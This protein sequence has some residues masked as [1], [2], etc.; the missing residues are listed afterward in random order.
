MTL[1]SV[2][3][4]LLEKIILCRV[5][6]LLEQ[7]GTVMPHPLQFVFVKEHGSIPAI[8]ILKESINF[9]N[10]HK[11]SVFAIFLDN[12]IAFDRIWQVGLLIKLMHI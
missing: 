2:L 11:L 9:N 1:T 7:I 8:H 4:K 12:E 5:Q 6:D 10:E 3:G